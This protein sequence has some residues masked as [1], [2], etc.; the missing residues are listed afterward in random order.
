MNFAGAVS[1]EYVQIGQ[2]LI[3]KIKLR[4]KIGQIDIGLPK[5][6]Y[7]PDIAPI[8]LFL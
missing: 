7:R 8:G 2:S 6:I 1:S 5:G 3:I 4:L